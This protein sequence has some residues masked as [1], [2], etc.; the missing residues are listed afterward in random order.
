MF[1]L[2]I[3]VVLRKKWLSSINLFVLEI[4]QKTLSKKI[5]FKG[6]GLHSGKNSEINLLPAP[7][8][9]GIVFK[10]VDLKSKNI[11]KANFA[12]VS[13]AK[14]CT[15]LEND[16]GVKVSTVEH[17]LAALYISGIDN[18]LIEINNE[19]VPIMDG[20]SKEFI[21]AL[22]K[23]NLIDQTEKRKYL[24]IS[25][26]IELLDGERKISIE[27]NNLS[28]EVN[29]QL[30][31]KNKIIGKQ[32]NI[33]DFQKDNLDQ[34]SSSRTFCLFEDIE[35]IKKLGLAKGGSLE[36]AVV[37]DNDKVL[38]E[39]GLRN[40]KEFVNHKILDLAGDFLLSGYRIAGKVICYQGGH[41][42]TNL[43]LK[44]IFKTKM[45]FEVIELNS[46]KASKKFYSKELEK[47]AVNA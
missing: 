11:I 21:R 15:T 26:K 16:H 12:N 14:L 38:N 46:F 42:L 20:S 25:N 18:V 40:Q 30:N 37:V 13:S 28:L 6:I 29:F 1:F 9:N 41:E 27:P 43:L 32:K 33:V 3:I 19:E 45:A 7:A 34:V 17:L 24:K 35:K 10:R 4:Y 8:N 23:A 22:K 2:E 47:I 36:N 31:Y 39:D 5:G 44:K